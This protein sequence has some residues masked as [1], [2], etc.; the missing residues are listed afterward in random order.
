MYQ[1]EV[2]RGWF[3]NRNYDKFNT[4]MRDDEG[5]LSFNGPQKDK[6]DP[7]KGHIPVQSTVGVLDLIKASSLIILRESF[8]QLALRFL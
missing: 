4:S 2:R 6:H 5:K 3:W 8:F 7:L 1:I